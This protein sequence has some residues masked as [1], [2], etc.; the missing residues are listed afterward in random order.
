MALRHIFQAGIHAG[1]AAPLIWLSWAIPSGR[2]G[3]DPVEELT[4]FL[5]MGALRL[6]L[7]TLC[8]TPLAKNLRLRGIKSSDLMRLR[9]P[10][11]L[12]CFAWASLHFAVW[13]SLDLQFQW[14][15]IGAEII[16]RKY[17]LVGF[18]AWLV[19]SALAI[20]SIPKLQ[21][22][23]GASWKKLHRWI[24]PVAVLVPLHFLWSVKSGLFEPGLY[25]V[26]TACLLWFRRKLF[27]RR[28]P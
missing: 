23:M 25:I 22:A 11:G 24:Y 20:T 12:W 14:S 19:L 26:M 6:L 8:L 15:F 18:V 2:L 5:G 9:R 28:N 10:L 13:L 3:G 4:H 21:R 1:A 7:L 27:I 16:K 17:L